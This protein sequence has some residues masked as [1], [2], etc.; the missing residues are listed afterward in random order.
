[1]LT[2]D[3]RAY[4]PDH[5]EVALDLSNLAL[6][7]GAT[8]RLVEAEA[9]FERALEV[10]EARLGRENKLVACTLSSLALLLQRTGRAHLAEPMMRRALAINE[11]RLRHH[12]PRDRNW[13]EQPGHVARE[14]GSQD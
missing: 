4:G 7:L 1:M 13:L 10:Q 3:E 5:H 11:K 2:I 12:A 8:N 6:L 14:P 9:A